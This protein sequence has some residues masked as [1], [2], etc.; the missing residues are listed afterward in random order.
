M[1]PIRADDLERM[2]GL[3]QL[4][5]VG[6]EVWAHHGVFAQERRDGQ[7]FRIDVAWWQNLSAAGAGDD[8]HLT[9]D[10]A[11]L[12]EFVVALVQTRPVAL[13]ETL[14]HRIQQGLLTR[15]P[16]DYVRVC[17]HKPDAPMAVGVSDVVL[18]SSIA[19]RGG[20]DRPE[21]EIVISLGSNIEPRLDHLQFAVSALYATAGLSDV[22]VS[23]VYETT[24]QSEVAQPDFLN[25][26]LLARSDLSALDLLHRGQRIEALAHRVRT[27]RHGRRS[28]DID[29]VKVGEEVWDEPE[30]VLPHPLAAERAFVL[31]PWLALDPQA[32]LSNTPIRGMI[33]AVGNQQVRR[34]PSQLFL[35]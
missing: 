26:V 24:A 7:L 3:D 28:L 15:Y 29:L 19:A 8:L 14:A 16:M 34:L 5:V 23:P 12:S 10:Y 33:E 31:I 20:P 18:T 6:L 9:I 27:V 13:I 30:L 17:V 22:R 11:E 21:R 35:P 2:K 4:E 32:R 25:A 1:R